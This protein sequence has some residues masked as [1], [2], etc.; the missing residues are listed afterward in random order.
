MKAVIHVL[1]LLFILPSVSKGVEIPERVSLTD[2]HV[3]AFAED[4][5]GLVWIGTRR[6][7]NRF[8][9]ISNHPILKGEES[10]INDQIL[11]LLP[12]E[13]GVL[14]GT[15]SGIERVGV[16][17]T[18]RH[19]PST[20]GD[21]VEDITSL[22]DGG[23]LYI[24]GEQ[25]RE[26]DPVGG[27]IETRCSV[28]G[29]SNGK[30]LISD[31]G[32][33]WI[34]G[35]GCDSIIVQHPSFLTHIALPLNG[36]PF[37]DWTNCH[38]GNIL[39]C[40]GQGGILYDS[41]GEQIPLTGKLKEICMGADV[42]FAGRDTMEGNIFVGIKGK[43]LF[44]FNQSMTNARRIMEEEDFS[45]W[46]KA[47]FLAT[48]TNIWMS[49][50]DNSF[51]FYCR[52][53]LQRLVH[54]GDELV[55]FFP[56][57]KGLLVV[58]E[59][60]VYSWDA[61]SLKLT[62]LMNLPEEIQEAALGEDGELWL[63]SS[64]RLF[65]YRDLHDGYR[66]VGQ[67]PVQGTAHV[68]RNSHGKVFLFMGNCVYS[69]G[70][71]MKRLAPLGNFVSVF[72]SSGNSS[73]FIMADGSIRRMDEEGNSVPIPG[74]IDLPSFIHECTDGNLLVCSYDNGVY[75]LDPTTGQSRRLFSDK[76]SD[77]VVRAAI[78]DRDGN[79]WMCSRNEF[80]RADAGSGE[81][82][83]LGDISR[84]SQGYSK[85]KAIQLE[86]GEIVFGCGNA[87]SFFNHGGGNTTTLVPIIDMIQIEGESTVN[88][89]DPLVLPYKKNHLSFVFS[90]IN[91]DP[92]IHPV[93]EYRMMGYDKDWV[94]SGTY[95]IAR[96]ALNPGKFTLQVRCLQPGGGYGEN[97]AELRIQILPHP[98]ASAPAIMLYLCALIILILFISREYTQFKLNKDRAEYAENEKLLIEN[99]SRE[100]IDF[101]TNISHEFRTP[102]SL[103]YGPLEELSKRNTVSEKDRTLVVMAK[104]S[105]ERLL[106][107]SDQLLSFQAGG[108]EDLTL[109][110]TNLSSL[111][112]DMTSQFEYLF[113]QKGQRLSV[114]VPDGLK[115]LCDREKV[116]K[117]FFNL[118]S[119]ASKYTPQG[120][121]VSVSLEKSRDQIQVHVADTGVGISS[122]AKEKIFNRFER[123]GK[124]KGTTAVSGFGIGLNYS[125]H[126][127]QLHHGGI[128]VKDNHPQ[129]S[130]FTLYFP[131]DEK[132]YVDAVIWS[133]QDET[134]GSLPL[135]ERKRPA[136]DTSILLV[137]DND[138]MR[139]FLCDILGAY[140]KVT[141]VSDGQEA[142]DWLTETTPDIIISDVMMPVKDGFTLCCEVKDNPA[143][144]HVP[145]ILLTAKSDLPS[146]IKGMDLGADAYV[147]KPFET[148][149]LLSV[150]CGILENRKKMQEMLLKKVTSGDPSSD[151]ENKPQ[152]LP[153]NKHDEVFLKRM[154]ALF[155]QRLADDTFGVASLAEELGLSRSGVFAKTKALLGESPQALLKDYR[156]N[157]AMELLKD[158]GLNVSEVCYSVGFSTPSGFSKAF[159]IKFGKSPKQV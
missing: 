129:G 57:G 11:S 69:P 120:G 158:G 71:S 37:R 29:L 136:A 18:V 140:C 2:P 116:E 3:S 115:A 15:F 143:T 53:P 8:N 121:S 45:R 99:L 47:V 51:K 93:Y 44:I 33:I 26:F 58:T 48:D 65:H 109:R 9:G 61:G 54:L 30:L 70:D 92:G 108:G 43:G 114:S 32:E 6:G 13:G 66:L 110:M 76:L 105:S 90:A 31:T 62:S 41:H 147:P 63:L 119:N 118:L 111:V 91:T 5:S 35:H 124:E 75:S 27:T 146:R 153:L 52:D 133:E 132:A 10:L 139:R 155:E 100:K 112:L 23:I 117:I 159:K 131:C 34:G 144:C 98:L 130:V 28:P 19:Y 156:L 127:A 134:N 128:L 157:K 83:V 64:K 60:T 87:L 24:S 94:E 50:G 74:T 56:A 36:A 7:L 78:K 125:M 16:D 40:T 81:V 17:G 149:Y 82:M 102:V 106:R 25:V 38:G 67:H 22:P 142:T 72:P 137:E 154:Y 123:L 101:Y 49:N 80:S 39:V 59:L 152:P 103:I 4:H 138:D 107:L 84:M 21:S 20:W 88:H 89:G 96:Y 42:L 73:L 77:Y 1:I 150:V 85:V 135:K 95:G 46:S 55:D 68:W 97:I 86:S 145:V 12:I 151:Q 126:L 14:V 122:D 104:R 79:I 113:Q 141:A 148:E